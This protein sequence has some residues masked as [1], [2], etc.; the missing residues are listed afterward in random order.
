MEANL[1]IKTVHYE[2]PE[3]DSDP[4]SKDG[5]A[6]SVL[7]AEDELEFAASFGKPDPKALAEGFNRYG[8]RENYDD[9]DR[10]VS[11][12]AV[13]EAMEPGGPD[14]R[15]GVRITPEFLR[16]VAEKDYNPS[17]PYIMDHQRETLAHIGFVKRV[18]YDPT[19]EKLNLMTRT[20][21]TG[22]QTHDE[23]ISRLTNDPPVL[24]DG[25]IG[26]GR[27]YEAMKNDDGEIELVDGRIRE[28]ST[29]PF[30]GGYDQGGLRAAS[31]S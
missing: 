17:P 8:I 3:K 28:F 1:H 21:N 10:L 20:Y 9:E 15:N 23:I 27:D 5:L 11:V 24:T 22:A 31:P 7:H 29:T 4:A 13:F 26:F 19:R 2:L 18:W 30:P 14:D 12:D 16:R 6:Y 25:S